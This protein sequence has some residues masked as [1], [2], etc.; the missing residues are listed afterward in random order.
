MGHSLPDL[1]DVITEI[2]VATSQYIDQVT[3]DPYYY[4]ATYHKVTFN[5]PISC[6]LE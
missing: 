6:S 3:D 1:Y 5:I 2:A 4:M